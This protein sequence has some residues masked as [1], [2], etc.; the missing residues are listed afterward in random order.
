MFITP[1]LHFKGLCVFVTAKL[2]FKGLCVF[3]RTESTR[4]EKLNFFSYVWDPISLDKIYFLQSR[5]RYMAPQRCN[6]WNST[7]VYQDRKGSLRQFNTTTHEG[8][9]A[10]L[11]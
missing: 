5:Y 3:H 7:N 11:Q 6:G 1:K 2:H 9:Y 8:S 10:T 4:V